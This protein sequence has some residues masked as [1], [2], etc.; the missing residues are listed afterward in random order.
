MKKG[1][2]GFYRGY[3]GTLIREM[4]GNACY[5]TMY[6]TIARLLTPHDETRATVSPARLM[7]AGSCSGIAY[8]TPCFPGI[9]HFLYWIFFY[10]S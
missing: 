2:R 1:L 4:P 8:W 3:L 7:I 6:E 9:L 10:L 5:F